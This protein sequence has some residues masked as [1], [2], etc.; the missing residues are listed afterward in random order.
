MKLKWIL[1]L[2][3]SLS[4]LCF[5]FSH[6]FHFFYETAVTTWSF[7]VFI[8][9]LHMYSEF[10]NS[11]KKD[12]YLKPTH[13]HTPRYYR[14]PNF[15][16]PLPHLPSILLKPLPLSCFMSH[17]YFPFSFL[18]FFL[19]YFP[20]TIRAVSLTYNPHSF[21]FLYCPGSVHLPPSVSPSSC[22][23]TFI[24]NEPLL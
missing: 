13:T 14:L 1:A 11:P 20:E 4:L 9:T 19:L 21:F 7:S 3:S 16:F 22:S 15:S 24:H 5:F 10:S 8:Y 2:A 17:H 12:E 18:P 23:L 6:Q